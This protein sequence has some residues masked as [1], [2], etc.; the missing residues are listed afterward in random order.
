MATHPRTSTAVQDRGACSERVRGAGRGYR[1]VDRLLH[2]ALSRIILLALLF[3][4]PT[5]SAVAQEPETAE[6][7]ERLLNAVWADDLA[8]L[9]ELSEDILP[10]LDAE[11]ALAI[12]VGSKRRAETLI[13]I[14][15][16]ISSLARRPGGEELPGEESMDWARALGEAAFG[17]AVGRALAEF[18]FADQERYV[19]P[20][21]AAESFAAAVK[22]IP[23]DDP[24]APGIHASAADNARLLERFG[25]AEE[26]LRGMEASLDLLEQ[27]S[28]SDAGLA[29]RARLHGIRAQLL[30]DVGLM[31]EALAEIGR[32]RQ[33]AE[34]HRERTGDPAALHSYQLRRTDLFLAADQYVR[35]L[36][37]AERQ[38][39]DDTLPGGERCYA[40]TQR[41]LAQVNLERRGAAGEE[42]ARSFLEEAASCAQQQQSSSFTIDSLR[43]ELAIDAGDHE[44][45]AELLRRNEALL[46]RAAEA[47]VRVEDAFLSA[48]EA[49]LAL[50]AG[51]DEVV[52]AA[53]YSRLLQDF[54]G[55]LAAWNAQPTRPG[56]HG[57]LHET[58]RQT[59]L[60][61]LMVLARQQAGDVAALEHVLEAQAAG[62][63]SRRAGVVAPDLARIRARLLTE[64]QGLLVFVP[65]RLR[66][67]VLLVDLEQVVCLELAPAFRLQA[68]HRRMQRALVTDP[69]RDADS[70]ET[71][72]AAAEELAAELLPP[73]ARRWLD[74]LQGVH[75]AGADWFGDLHLEA[76]PSRPGK[77]IGETHAVSNLPSVPF[78]VHLSEL[79]RSSAG[80]RGALLLVAP[81]APAVLPERLGDRK[82]LARLPLSS[83]DV[84]GLVAPFR[85]R[86][87][88]CL[89]GP[90]A[91]LAAL[92]SD[93]S[94]Y[95]FAH[96]FC[97]GVR[98]RW[99]ERPAGLLLADGVL[100]PE[101][102]EG[103]RS[104][105][106]LVL[107]SACG[108]ARG[109]TRIGGE[110]IG[111]LGGAFLLSG[112]RNVVL[113]SSEIALNPTLT[114]ATRFQRELELGTP[115]AEALRRARVEVSA[116][117]GWEH[118][119]YHSKLRLLGPGHRPVFSP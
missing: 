83:S 109:Q 4:L 25:V 90:Q 20:A 102:I 38:L 15:A 31:E 16:G 67:H 41:A 24:H 98:D 107:L 73:R 96:L 62:T 114:L 72:E 106:E 2:T 28:R 85:T 60:S 65:A 110:G 91:T 6:L 101:D 66:S 74:G 43:A 97:H 119:Y 99:R 93:E 21:A 103:L 58:M 33:P 116:T 86:G 50:T 80:R 1:G 30:A 79:P 11:G 71:L 64:G 68:A 59:T 35:A 8:S 52:L 81:E 5:R 13:W 56:G 29:D 40:L 112:A 26:L 12:E 88:R 57:F 78:G 53:A 3:G 17:E 61:E 113:A 10:V 105:P 47:P 95:V 23:L 55:L 111:H 104:V 94:D 87:V 42:L 39:A 108:A 76:L 44:A 70:L 46:A 22:W 92:R 48:L 89:E 115:P 19:R 14:A 100:W 54:H 9:Q 45:A 7:C 63:L 77:T 75:V 34:A 36:D 69:R 37:L 118:P 51:R 18:H 27:E 82:K 117:K 49:R 84:R 32:A